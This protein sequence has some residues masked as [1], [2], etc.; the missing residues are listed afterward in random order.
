MKPGNCVL[1][2][3][4]KALKFEI[5]VGANGLL[6]VNSP[7]FAHTTAILNA[8]ASSESLDEEE[9]VTMVD[10]II[11]NLQAQEQFDRPS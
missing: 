8:V 11:Q 3:L 4:A 5:A 1:N 9:T 6:W 10:A 2:E 7:N